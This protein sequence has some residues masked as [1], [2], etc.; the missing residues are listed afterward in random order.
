MKLRSSE[1]FTLTF[2]DRLGIF[3]KFPNIRRIFSGVIE[4]WLIAYWLNIGLILEVKCGDNVLDLLCWLYFRNACSSS[5]WP[6][7][8]STETRWW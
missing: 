2:V 1:V 6:V 3:S 7:S 4:I 5:G 8:T